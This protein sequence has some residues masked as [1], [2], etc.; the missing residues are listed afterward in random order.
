[1]CEVSSPFSIEIGVLTV[2]QCSRL[3]LYCSKISTFH[4]VYFMNLENPHYDICEVSLAVFRKL[5]LCKL[6][7][8]PGFLTFL[9]GFLMFFDVTVE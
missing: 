2:A 3:V 1:M 9:P 6:L 5:R 8:V 7:H 4:R